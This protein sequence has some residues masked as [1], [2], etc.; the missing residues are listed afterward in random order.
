MTKVPTLIL[1]VDK[2]GWTGGIQISIEDDEIGGYRIAGPKYN[3]SSINLL[4]RVLTQRDA[5]EIR[6]YLDRSFPI[7]NAT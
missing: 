6:D 3:G 7:T 2:D 1:R 5:E 4:K